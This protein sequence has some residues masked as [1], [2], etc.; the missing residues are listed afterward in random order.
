[1]LAGS[2][3]KVDE[4]DFGAGRAG[5]RRVS[6][7]ERASRAAAVRSADRELAMMKDNV[8]LRGIEGKGWG[9]EREK[10]AKGVGGRDKRAGNV[11]R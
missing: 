8:C 3:S 10:R 1:M 6:Q 11:E 5:V 4:A 2:L 9:G 7:R